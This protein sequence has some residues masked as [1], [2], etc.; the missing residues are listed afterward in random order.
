MIRNTCEARSDSAWHSMTIILL[1]NR[2]ELKSSSHGERIAT[3]GFLRMQAV[4][5]K[6]LDILKRQLVKQIKEHS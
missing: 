4:D 6:R 5:G 2:E 3:N 1:A